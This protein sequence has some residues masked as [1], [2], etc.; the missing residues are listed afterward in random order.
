[1]K[2]NG[3]SP[4]QMCTDF[5]LRL[6]TYKLVLKNHSE[7]TFTLSKPVIIKNPTRRMSG[8]L[9]VLIMKDIIIDNPDFQ[10]P[11]KFAIVLQVKQNPV[12]QLYNLHLYLLLMQDLQSQN[13]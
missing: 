7:R 10:G 4:N 2:S 12:N 6:L 9:C 13:N 1:M 8:S 5:N 11:N 3:Q